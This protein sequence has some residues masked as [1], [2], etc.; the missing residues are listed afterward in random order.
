MKRLALSIL[1]LLASLCHGMAADNPDSLALVGAEWKT[2]KLPHGAVA[3]TARISIFG[4]QQTLS[5]IRYRAKRLDTRIVQT[6]ELTRTSETAIAKGAVAAI[7]AG[8]W[9]VRKVVPSTY[10]RIGGCDMSRTEARELFRVNGILAIGRR[11]IEVFECD[12]TQYA[13]YAAIYDDILASGS[14]LID[15]G[16]I[17]DYSDRKGGFFGRHPRSAIGTDG[18]GEIVLL[19]VDGRFKGDADGMTIGELAKVCRWLGL[20]D[21]INLDGGGSC[22]L[23]C[24]EAG[25][26][27]HPYDN[28]RYDHD[29][30]RAVSSCIVVLPKKRDVGRGNK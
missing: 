12:T 4:S 19:T 11:G 13:R 17:P 21:A 10:V 30:E 8:Y 2:V 20:T 26:L 28:K 24:R 5:L 9:N 18:R 7:N 6:R 27:N 3:R 15:D 1:L 14:V 16:R 23:W 22:T 25:I 29:G